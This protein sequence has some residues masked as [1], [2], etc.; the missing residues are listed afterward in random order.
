MKRQIFFTAWVGTI[1]LLLLSQALAQPP[2]T[3]WTRTFGGSNY[4]YCYSVQQTTDGGYILGGY[5]SSYGA[6]GYDFWLVKTDANGDSLWSRTFGGSNHDY[7]S[8]V[9]QTTDGGYILGGIT[10]SYGAG[11][12]DFWLVRAD[13]NGDTLWTRTFGGYYEERCYSIQ[14]TTDGGY[15]LGGRTSSYGAGGWDVCLIKVD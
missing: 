11:N 5:T 8:S 3:L 10:E 9:Q 12:Y 14:Q 7:C 15:I 1:L 4:D 2:D 13:A 6:G